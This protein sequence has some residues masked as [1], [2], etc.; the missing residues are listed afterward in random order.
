[1]DKSLLK[2]ITPRRDAYANPVFSPPELALFTVY[3]KWTLTSN[4]F[5]N[6][7][8]QPTT[9]NPQQ[10]TYNIH[11]PPFVTFYLFEKHPKFLKSKGVKPYKNP[12]V[13]P[14]N[15]SL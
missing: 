4:N 7:Q 9:R 12:D 6:I 15:V 10:T 11:N 14:E 13:S 5:P 3:R 2:T 8:P 1:M